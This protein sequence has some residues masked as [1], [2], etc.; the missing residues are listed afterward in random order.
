MSYSSRNLLGLKY[1]NKGFHRDTAKNVNVF[2]CVCICVAAVAGMLKVNTTGAVEVQTCSEAVYT[3]NPSVYRLDVCQTTEKKKCLSKF[4]FLIS[5]TSE[6]DV[7]V[8]SW[9]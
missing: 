5:F 9:W 8:N 7:I 3:V 2:V 6:V 1:L 4:K